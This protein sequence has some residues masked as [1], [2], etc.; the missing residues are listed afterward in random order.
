ML[1]LEKVTQWEYYLMNVAELMSF[2]LMLSSCRDKMRL[3]GVSGM[4]ISLFER[5]YNAALVE[6]ES[7]IKEEEILPV[8]EH[9]VVT[10]SDAALYKSHGESLLNSLAVIKLNGGLG[11]TMGLSKA[12]SLLNVKNGYSFLEIIINQMEFL[13]KEYDVTVP[14]LLMNSFNT[15]E[16]T[17]AA[18]GSF[19]N[20]ELD[21][22][23]CF[24]QGK[25]PKLDATTYG[26]AEYPLKTESEWN[27]P[28][29]G[30]VY[31]SLASSGLLDVLLSKGIRFAF[32]SN[33]DNLGATVSPEILGYMEKTG[34][35]FLMEVAKRTEQ[36][37]K[38]GHLAKNHNGRLILREVA[39]CLTTD[40]KYFQ[41]T[42]RHSMFN[43]NSVWIDLEALKLLLE[44]EIELA[45]IC[46]A[47]KC[48]PT[49]DCSIDVIQLEIAMG[50]LVSSYPDAKILRVPRSR[51]LPVKRNEDLM[52]IRSDGFILDE[53]WRLINH[54]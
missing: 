20:G 19:S 21:I 40:L 50:N 23:T 37:S 10:L 27:P 38:G 30:D 22:P 31:F 52:R 46:N 34:I 51:F 44:T 13:R 41:D 12:K 17:I 14:L 28:G 25:F 2:D 32:I 5:L 29:H 33:T 36:D 26:P 35:P 39:H 43:T 8:C 24:L 11:T 18:L 4:H 15:N 1:N 48:D 7:F 45:P 6:G 54:A 16:D 47:K 42:N 9:D 53:G 49:S 3:E